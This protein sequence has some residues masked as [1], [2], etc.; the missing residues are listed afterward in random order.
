MVTKDNNIMDNKPE[1]EKPKRKALKCTK[2]NKKLLL[3]IIIIILGAVGFYALLNIRMGT[4]G[5]NLERCVSER[6]D[7]YCYALATG[8]IKYCDEQDDPQCYDDVNFNK[9]I[10][11]GNITYCNNVVE[12][13]GFHIACKILS[14][15]QG[16]DKCTEIRDRGG[17]DA[18]LKYIFCRAIVGKDISICNEVPVNELDHCRD[19]YYLIVSILDNDITLCDKISSESEA[20]SCKA[21]LTKNAA[22]CDELVVKRCRGSI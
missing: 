17:E 13:V 4:G 8:D 18:E 1:N 10:E 22:F 16:T 20:F 19:S 12:N 2:I 15:S 5:G 7:S 14:Q 3:G 9:A 21:T 11:D 6:F